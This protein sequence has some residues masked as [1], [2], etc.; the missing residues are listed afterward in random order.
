M[1]T[2]TTGMIMR[3]A[4]RTIITI[5]TPIRIRTIAAIATTMTSAGGRRIMQRPA[6]VRFRGD[7]G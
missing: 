3:T 5:R 2:T 4:M 6:R 7:G 1:A